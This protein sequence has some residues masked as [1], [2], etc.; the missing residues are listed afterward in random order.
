MAE[1]KVE[2]PDELKQDMNKL[3]EIEWSVAIRRFLKQELD[4]L[5]ELKRIVSKSKLSEKDALE[6]SKEVNKSLAQ[7]FKQSVKS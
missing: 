4:R 7:R 3:P 5:L 6:L 1:L 2:I